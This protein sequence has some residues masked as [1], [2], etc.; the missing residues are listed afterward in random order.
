MGGKTMKWFRINSEMKRFRIDGDMNLEKNYITNI[1]VYAFIQNMETRMRNWFKMHELDFVD[2]Y[3][4]DYTNNIK[5]NGVYRFNESH[6]T[7]MNQHLMVVIELSAMN[8]Q[9]R[10]NGKLEFVKQEYGWEVRQ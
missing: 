6:L 2:I 4:E 3:V 9:L 8:T 10:I 7:A 1:G 5:I